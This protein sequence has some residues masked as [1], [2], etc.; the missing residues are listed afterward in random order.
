MVGMCGCGLVVYN[1]PAKIKSKCWAFLE[2]ENFSL[3]PQEP[4]LTAIT[5]HNE[6]AC[7]TVHFPSFVSTLGS[8]LLQIG[9]ASES[10]VTETPHLSHG[11]QQD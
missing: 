2:K 8:P 6:K 7:A 10:S 9:S 4:L 1:G 5:V 11:G 3:F